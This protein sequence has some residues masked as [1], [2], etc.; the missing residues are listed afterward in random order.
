MPSSA[1]PTGFVEL[2]VLFVGLTADG[3]LFNMQGTYVRCD[4]PGGQADL[5][6]HTIPKLT[7]ELFSQRMN[8]CQSEGLFTQ[9]RVECFFDAIRGALESKTIARGA[10][11]TISV[12]KDGSCEH[13]M[14]VSIDFEKRTLELMDSRGCDLTSAEQPAETLGYYTPQ[15]HAALL[16]LLTKQANLTQRLSFQSD[17]LKLLRPL[18]MDRRFKHLARTPGACRD[19]CLYYLWLRVRYPNAQRKVHYLRVRAAFD[20]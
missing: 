20:T 13:C 10:V 17:E 9:G 18:P 15:A 7:R 19:A 8:Q 11:G 1:T 14:C 3:S 4:T 5:R 16:K 2:P 6:R 12:Q